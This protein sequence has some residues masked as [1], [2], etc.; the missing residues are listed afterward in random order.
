MDAKGLCDHG[1]MVRE[2]R[3]VT[4]I[5]QW[6]IILYLYAFRA[7]ILATLLAVVPSL[8]PCGDKVYS[9]TLF[10][11]Y[12]RK[13][14]FPQYLFCWLK[15]ER[16][17]SCRKCSQFITVTHLL[18]SSWDAHGSFSYNKCLLYFSFN[19]CLGLSKLMPLCVLTRGAKG[20]TSCRDERPSFAHKQNN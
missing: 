5:L 9:Y 20:S 7:N 16:K 15:E 6:I 11:Y 2:S 18:S 13:I 14:I 17:R 4:T 10:R 3:F 8:L 19:E 12:I 1:I